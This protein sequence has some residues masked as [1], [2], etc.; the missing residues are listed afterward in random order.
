LSTV[1]FAQAILL[2]LY[3]RY[4]SFAALFYCSLISFFVMASLLRLFEQ[5]EAVAFA[6]I[7]E[8]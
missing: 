1:I 5:E 2:N 4:Q 8:D 7:W 3:R 6:L